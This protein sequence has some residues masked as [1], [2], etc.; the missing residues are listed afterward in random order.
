MS[1]IFCKDCG[2]IPKAGESF[3]HVCLDELHEAR[4]AERLAARALAAENFLGIELLDAYDAARMRVD[5]LEAAT[6]NS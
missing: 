2:F 3:I 6:T 1:D 5:E 4:E